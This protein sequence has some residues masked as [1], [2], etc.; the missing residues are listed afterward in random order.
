MEEG[1]EAL[2]KNTRKILDQFIWDAHFKN[3]ITKAPV[4]LEIWKK[5]WKITRQDCRG[6]WHG[7]TG[8]I[9]ERLDVKS[10]EWKRMITLRG[11]ITSKCLG[12]YS[13]DYSYLIERQVKYFKG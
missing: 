12:D 9:A 7:A 13:H 11:P 1:E 4:S 3:H 6:Y 2:N 8:M 5:Y 10:D